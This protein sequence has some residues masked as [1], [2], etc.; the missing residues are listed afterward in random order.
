[1]AASVDWSRTG[2]CVPASPNWREVAEIPSIDAST[3]Y[4]ALRT[5]QSSRDP[6]RHHA[7]GPRRRI[8]L[9]GELLGDEFSSYP[10]EE[11]AI[12]SPPVLHYWGLL[13]S[14]F[15]QPQ[16]LAEPPRPTEFYYHSAAH[17]GAWAWVQRLVS[18]PARLGMLTASAGAGTT[19]LLRQLTTTSGLG[20][21]AIATAKAQW[22]DQ[23]I[24]DL[25]G[26][27]RRTAEAYQGPSPVRSIWFID[28]ATNQMG[29]GFQRAVAFSKWYENHA[30]SLSNVSVVMV[31]RK[32]VDHVR[33]VS[34]ATQSIPAHHLSRTNNHDLNQCVSAAMRHAGGTRPAFTVAATSRL[35][36]AAAGSIHRLGLL[37]HTALLHGYHARL[38][39]VS[40][41]DLGSGI[42]AASPSAQSAEVYR[43]A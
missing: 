21:T 23:S 19:T 43:T 10:V 37:V 3:R 26:K 36:E 35:A 30:P 31:V 7:A 16:S 24:D 29:A 17:V 5:K 12:L 8:F 22:G 33:L 34:D 40:R 18:Q 38:R 1:M 13:A 42:T 41:T 2:K 39:Q 11:T 4:P 15:A 14:P 27:L 25:V 20:D 32:S 28:T 9:S 6:R